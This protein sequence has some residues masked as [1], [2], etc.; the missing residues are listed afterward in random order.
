MSC[1]SE[2]LHRTSQVVPVDQK[3]STAT[4]PSRTCPTLRPEDFAQHAAMAEV[5]PCPPGNMRNGT[6]TDLV[7]A[8][9]SLAFLLEQSS[10]GKFLRHRDISTQGGDWIKGVTD[11]SRGNDVPMEWVF[12]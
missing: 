11:K 2:K 1:E 5:E 8:T 4:H 12:L 6:Q 10:L 9:M 7:N 3:D